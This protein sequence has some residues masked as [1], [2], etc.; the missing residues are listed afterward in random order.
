MYKRAT[1]RSLIATVALAWSVLAQAPPPAPDWRH[2]GNSVVDESL[3]GSAS[4]PVARVWYSAG[5]ATLFLQTGSGHL[6]QTADLENWRPS[7]AVPPAAT[8]SAPV[9]RLPEPGAQVRMP[10]A[11]RTR[12]YAF[13]KFVYRSDDGGAT[14]ENLTAYRSASI[15]GPGLH[16]LAIAPGNG[17]ELVVAGEAGLFRSADGGIS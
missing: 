12:A 11:Q 6:F 9:L 17:D 13:G 15:V 5:G 7:V 16:D 10:L 2:I 14:W 8:D 4:G 3:C 1:V